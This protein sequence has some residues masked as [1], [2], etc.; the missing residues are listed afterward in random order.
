MTNRLHFLDMLHLSWINI[1]QHKVRSAI[2]ITTVSILFGLLIGVSFVLNGLETTL[3]DVSSAKTDGKFYVITYHR[4]VNNNKIAPVNSI[5]SLLSAHHATTLGTLTTYNFNTS[6]SVSLPFANLPLEVIDL[7]AV[8]DFLATDLDQ[9]PTAKIPVLAPAGGFPAANESD[10]DTNQDQW[11]R[12]QIDTKYYIVGYLPIMAEPDNHIREITRPGYSDSFT[13]TIPGGFNLLNLVLGKINYGTT[14]SMQP[15][16]I[17]DGSGKVDTYIGELTDAWIQA[18]SVEL[19]EAFR[20]DAPARSEYAIARFD[21][22]QDLIDYTAPTAEELFGNSSSQLV[23]YDLTGNASDVTIAFHYIRLQYIAIIAVILITAVLITIFTFSQLVD[24]DAPTIALYHSMGA[25]T[26]N[27]SLIY[28]FYLL[29]LC[30]LTIIA[31]LV[32]GLIFSGATA[33]LNAAPFAQRLQDF[34]LLSTTPH[35]SFLG[36]SQDLLFI[37]LAIIA[38]APIVLA[39]TQKHFSAQYV[40]KRLKAR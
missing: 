14:A 35:V 22:A 6:I 10:Q 19:E 9:V 36:I 5:S 29:E 8:T 3:L 34:Y 21:G 39:F 20:R 32:I 31:S 25:S 18:Q 28:L 4:Q 26:N 2:I 24:Q 38:T 17:D 37:I 33:A 11:L 40:A 13:P 30:I 12:E 1:S 27:I 23:T 15:I 16:L 7:S